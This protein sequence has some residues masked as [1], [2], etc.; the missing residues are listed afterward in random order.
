MSPSVP[1]EQRESLA[2]L[3]F[4]TYEG[5]VHAYLRD[6]L[7]PVRRW[8]PVIDAIIAAGPPTAVDAAD[9]IAAFRES[10]PGKPASHYMAALRRAEQIARGLQPKTEPADLNHVT[11]TNPTGGVEQCERR[12]LHAGHEWQ[13]EFGAYF[14]KWCPGIPPDQEEDP[15]G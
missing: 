8:L 5:G 11:K 7:V 9:A 2:R 3:A 14:N 4:R 10:R 1:D 6:D 12:I 15:Y 13:A